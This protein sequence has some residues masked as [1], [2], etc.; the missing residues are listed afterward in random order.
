MTSLT[1]YSW[2]STYGQV[3]VELTPYEES[4]FFTLFVLL[5][6]WNMFNARAFATGHSAFHNLRQCRGFGLIAVV[7][8][9][10]Q[11]IIVTI[12]GQMF[13]VT[14][15]PPADWFVIIA[16]T[17]LVLWGGELKRLFAKS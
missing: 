5:Q 3:G 4:V 7:I 12:G 15:L 13:N 8:L 14:P 11:I 2:I 16:V 9:V 17:S 6:F 1:D 10:G